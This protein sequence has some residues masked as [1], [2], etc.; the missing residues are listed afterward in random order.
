MNLSKAEAVSMKILMVTR[1]S[2]ADRR[3]GL[4]QSLSPLIQ[5]LSRRGLATDY[6][7]Q[8]DL[9]QRA[10]RWQLRLHRV[11]S[12]FAS[13]GK[14]ST[15][16]PMLFYVL[17]ERFNV[18]RLAAK[19]AVRDGYTHVHC[20][21]PII[22]AG[23][24]FFLRF[25]PACR[26]VWG[27]TEHGF[28][29]Y[30]Q[31]I[32]EDGIHL[33]RHVMNGMRKWEK[34]TLLNASWVIAP[35]KSGIAQIARDLEISPVPMNWYHI[36]HALPKLNPYSK[37]ESRNRLDWNEDIV[38]LLAV[39]RIAP[40]KQF[41]LLIQACA[42]LKLEKGFQ[43]VILGDGNYDDLQKLAQQLG[44]SREIIFTTTEDIG[45]YLCAADLYISTSA[46]E[47]FGIANLE[48]L[49]MG[50]PAI[51]TAVGGVP[52]VVGDGALLIEPELDALIAAI[53][54]MLD[55]RE[56]REA[57]AQKGR[58]RAKTWPDI[59]KITDIY[60]AIYRQVAAS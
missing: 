35:T 18:G 11:L 38:Y 58:M 30:A 47:S 15:N 36:P 32:H 60:E 53:Q 21:D 9:G 1:E 41:A 25:Q 20:H 56:F 48:A 2:Q 54:S 14:T 57:T 29:C 17:L 39:G 50:A 10:V 46:S 34:S 40:V 49:A 52:E 37:E 26:L 31:A 55:D 12:S 51:C 42:K 6:L 23:F 3:Y 43:L 59:I 24:C 27:V 13:M 45:L 16:F 7:C 22:A 44:F 19:V 28:G 8:V 4:G 5:E 33:G